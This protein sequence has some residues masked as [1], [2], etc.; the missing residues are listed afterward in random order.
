MNYII[1][2]ERLIE[3]I[4]AELNLNA[5]EG[6]GVDNWDWYG[7][8]IENYLDRLSEEEDYNFIDYEDAAE[9]LIDKYYEKEEA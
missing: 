7:E 6:G 3:L 8:S 1:P 5:L 4:V 9:L 2:R